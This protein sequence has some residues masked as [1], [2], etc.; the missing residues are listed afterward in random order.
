MAKL[1]K[2]QYSKEEY[3]RLKSQQK[4]KK[5]AAKQGKVIP[6]LKELS[7][8]TSVY[9]HVNILCVKHGTKYS[10]DYVNKLYNMVSR[11][12]NLKFHFHCLTD[13]PTDINPNIHII[14]LPKFL[15]GWWCKPYIFSDEL[16]IEGTILY[17]D[18][19]MVI[20]NNIDNMFIYSPDDWCII[21]DFTRHIRPDWKKYNSSV[22]RFK[23]GQLAQLWNEYSRDWKGVQSKFFGDQDWLYEASNKANMPA[24]LFPDNWVKSWKW[25]IRKSKELE[26]G[27]PK[28]ERIFK[29]IEHVEPPKDCLI[30]VFH[31]DPNPHNCKDPW[32]IN[33]W[34]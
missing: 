4:A 13:N 34:K 7:N 32:V 29:D 23:R 8:V 21:R 12:C 25:E 9:D 27:R 26:S 14:D 10:A 33:N 16:P 24:N 22:I 6:S 15:Q 20:A 30:A 17:L 1:D 5:R 19:D 11:Y 18:L 3:R 2:S 31:G 28:G